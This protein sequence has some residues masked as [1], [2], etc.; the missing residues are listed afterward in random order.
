MSTPVV[1]V[2][3]IS[4]LYLVSPLYKKISVD[5]HVMKGDLL[6][7]YQ[8]EQNFDGNLFIHL[9]IIILFLLSTIH[10]YTHTIPPRGKISKAFLSISSFHTYSYVFLVISHLVS[11]RVRLWGREY[12]SSSQ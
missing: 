12:N 6:F 3:M 2:M 9:F 7:F 10:T 5:M 8:I 1:V 4:V 11:Q